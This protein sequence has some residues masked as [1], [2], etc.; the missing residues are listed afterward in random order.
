MLTWDK[1]QSGRHLP[2]RLKIVAIAQH[3]HKRSRTQGP[4]PLHLLQPL[5]RFHLMA[6]ARELTRDGGNTGLQRTQLTLEGR[7]TPT[8]KSAGM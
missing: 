3:C 6:E 8:T 2:T 7:R 4:N 5:T 1:V